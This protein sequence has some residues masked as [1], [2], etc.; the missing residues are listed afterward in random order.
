[1]IPKVIHYCWFGRNPLPKDVKECIKSWKKYCPDYE[2][3][4]WDED[5]FDINCHPFVKEAYEQKAWAFVSDFARLKV[6]LENGGVYFDTDVELLKN[7]DFL[8][9]NG[10]FMGITQTMNLC[11][12]G[13]GFGAE[14]GNAVIE[15]MLKKYDNVSL[16]KQSRDELAC[17]YLNSAVVEEMGYTFSNEIVKLNGITI[18]PPRYFDPL[19][20]GD[21]QNLLCEDT[22]SI[23]HYAATWTSKGN[24]FKRKLFRFIG[25]ENIHKLKKIFKRAK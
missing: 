4:R 5:N 24:R 19:S 16:L 21:T 20:V 13:L 8:L 17:P 23:H 18:Y 9:S 12:T 2:I 1:M 15:K 7:P 11:T 10:C 14:K 6:V 25:E 22:V 3:V